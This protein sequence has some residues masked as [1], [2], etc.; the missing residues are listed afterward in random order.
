MGVVGLCVTSALTINHTPIHRKSTM[1]FVLLK[2][3]AELRNKFS[4][5]ACRDDS[6]IEKFFGS[7]S[8][9]GS[10]KCF[11]SLGSTLNKVYR[12]L[13]IFNLGRLHSANYDLSLI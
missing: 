3:I 10:L 6:V 1:S 4:R 2:V 9:I 7:L 12:L 5:V 13:E 8:M 11:S